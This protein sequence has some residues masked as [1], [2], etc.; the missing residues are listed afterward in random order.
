MTYPT[1]HR[2]LT[3]EN[4]V[5][6][7]LIFAMLSAL[8][9]VMLMIHEGAGKAL[10]VTGIGGLIVIYGLLTAGRMLRG[11]ETVMDKVT[12]ISTIALL[13]G[14]SG[15]ICVFF[16]CPGHW[17]IMGISLGILLVAAIYVMLTAWVRRTLREEIRWIVLRLM[18]LSA[19]LVLM[20]LLP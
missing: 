10:I 16:K 1:H 13:A 7:E 2:L 9:M 18:L 20:G 8:G 5:T 12:V 15:S 4:L 19:V 3:S 6:F 14:L 17:W 11:R